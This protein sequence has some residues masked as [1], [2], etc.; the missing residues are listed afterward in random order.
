MGVTDYSFDHLVEAKRAT[1]N[2]LR[3]NPD[4]CTEELRSTAC[5]HHLARGRC[6]CH[7]HS[8][9]PP[10]STPGVRGSPLL[11]LQAEVPVED[12]NGHRLYTPTV[13][14]YKSEVFLNSRDARPIRI[15]CEYQDTQTRLRE[16]G[17]HATILFFGSARC[18]SFEDHD[19]QTTELEQAKEAASSPAEREEVEKKLVRHQKLRWVCEYMD[20]TCEL[21][22]RVTEWAHTAEAFACIRSIV[23]GSID[24]GDL[25]DP[26]LKNKSFS[27]HSRA[28][29][30]ISTGGG[31]GLMEA[32]NRGASLV[33]GGR[34]IG[35]GISLPFEPGLNKYVT[36]ELAFEYHYFFTRKFWMVYPCMGLV[37][38]PGGLGTLDELFEVL[39]L[40]QTRKIKLDVPIVL[41]G[42]NYWRTVVNW[43]VRGAAFRAAPT[44][45]RGGSRQAAPPPPPSPVVGAR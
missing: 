14:A 12:T 2:N 30:V 36:E 28:P 34:S 3:P 44:P 13:K 41:L 20:K 22:R 29:M 35:M 23:Q 45:Q 43:Q 27:S 42:S 21:A 33:P 31:P 9:V 19:K 38:T 11:A 39:T 5:R 24:S 26:N 18:S 17:I 1:G 16:N 8:S 40:K 7:P 6:L 4:T 15:L 37:C 25:V 10:P 32:A